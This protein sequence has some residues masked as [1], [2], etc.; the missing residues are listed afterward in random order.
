MMTTLALPEPK[1]T[2]YIPWRPSPKQRLFLLLDDRPE[3]LFGGAAGPGKSAGLLMAALQYV[4][5][6]HY[7]AL[8]LRR[9]FADLNKP[10]ALIPLAHEWLGPSDAV[11][12]QQDKQWTFPSGATLSFGYLEHEND[13]YHYQGAA[14]QFVGWD[15][16][17]QFSESQYS[18]VSFSR[19]RRRIGEDVPIRVRA[20]SNPGGVGHEWVKTRFVDAETREGGAIFIPAR[21]ADNPYIDK[22][23]YV[24][25]LMKLDPITRAQLL[26]GDWS[27]R[28]EGGY[29]KREWF[30]V[31]EEAEVPNDLTTVRFWDLAATDPEEGKDPDWTA[32]ARLGVHDGTVYIVDLIRRRESPNVIEELMR[33][34]AQQD[35]REVEV[36][37]EQEPG[38]SGKAYLDHLR[39]HIFQ[40]YTF[41][42]LSA[43]TRGS[44]TTLASPLS[45][46]A[47][48]HNVR[49]VR[50][51]WNKAF[52]EEAEAFP[53]GAH[54]DQIDAAASAYYVVTDTAWIQKQPRRR[55]MHGLLSEYQSR[56]KA[57]DNCGTQLYFGHGAE[58][59]LC[60]ACGKEN[61]A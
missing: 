37:A 57:C 55:V 16:L 30:E 41:S 29:F 44:K 60:Y 28:P 3:I 49:L 2:K 11:W 15:E 25:N 23:A 51:N 19:G 13:K 52:I 35:G 40:G 14:Y 56:M 24:A 18:Y 31:I 46:Q 39:R 47:E 43:S 34:T 59:Q 54:D 5:V 20:A 8:L 48:G 17:T 32:G 36:Y 22:E 26:N 1:L 27:V 12:N 4:D 53:L 61:A 38:A 33:A 6:P 7:N 58:T 42:V 21:L 45:S 50:G 9:T 10:D